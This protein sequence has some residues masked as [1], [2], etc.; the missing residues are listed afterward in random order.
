MEK[1]LKKK[2]PCIY[3]VHICTRV[4]VY[5]Y[6]YI[7][8][9]MGLPTWLSGKESTRQCRS[10]KRRRV[11]PWVR[12]TTW[13][14]GIAAHSSIL[15]WRILWT[16]D[17]CG[18]QSMGWQSQIQLKRLSTRPT[19]FLWVSNQGNSHC[20]LLIRWW[21][22]RDDVFKEALGDQLQELNFIYKGLSLS[23]HT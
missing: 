9:Y 2:K 11:N 3:C 17:P 10:W 6:V 12:K 13:R 20:P 14:R 23:S 15:A 19:P 1:N 5:I 18:L 21:I 22:I 8:T 4:H 7:Y 16:E